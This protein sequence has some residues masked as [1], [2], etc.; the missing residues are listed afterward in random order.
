MGN[1]NKSKTN[2]ISMCIQSTS[3][4][5]S[6]Q[7]IQAFE[8]LVKMMTFRFPSKYSFDVCSKYIQTSLC[9]SYMSTLLSLRYLK[10]NDS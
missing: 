8:R 9:G 2:E 10:G 6:N 4:K 5:V 3:C 7:F 1:P